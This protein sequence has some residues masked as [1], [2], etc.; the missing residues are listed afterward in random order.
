[1]F[2]DISCAVSCFQLKMSKEMSHWQWPN[3]ALEASELEV[4]QKRYLNT[5]LESKSTNVVYHISAF[6]ITG[7]SWSSSAGYNRMQMYSP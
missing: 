7:L 5:F 1:M 2:R 3:L 6:T 4:V